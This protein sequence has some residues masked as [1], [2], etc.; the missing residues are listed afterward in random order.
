MLSANDPM[1]SFLN[2]IQVVKDALSPLELGIRK[3]AEDLE[4][5]W[6]VS[7]NTRVN[8]LEF[9]STDNRNHDNKVQICAVKK[10]SYSYSNGN[11]GNS[12]AGEERKEGF[13][14]KVP[15]RA[16]LGMFSLNMENEHNK[17]NGGRGE[18]GKKGLKDREAGSEDGSCTNC[19]QFAVTWSLL[20]SGLVQAFPSPFKT[21][22][23]GFQKVGDDDR[24]NLHLCKNELKSKVSRE[25]KQRELQ[26]QYVKAVQNDRENHKEGKHVSLEC[27]IGFIFDQLA[28]NLQKFNQSLQQADVKG[29]DYDHSTPPSE[30]SQFDH[31]R[32]VMS[33][34]EGQKVD[35]NGFLG[36]LKFARV[37]GVPSGIVGVSSSVNEEGDD[38]IS[39][40]NGEE[41]GGSSPQKL[42][43][44]LLSI[45]L[46][47]VER[48]RSTLSAVSLSELI[49]LVPHL[50]RSS[51]DYPDKKKLF[52][53]QDFFRYTESE[54][55]RFFEELDRDGDGQV[56][57]EDLEIAMKKRKL[58][59]RY[60]R[61][62]M[63]RARSHLFSKSFGWKQFLSLMEQK[64]PTI[65]R[66]YTSLCLNKS[67]TL[68]KSEILASLKNA[69]LPANEDNAV[70]MMRF[71]NADTEES[72]SYGH[73]RNFMLLLPSDR[74]QDDPRSIW[75]EAATVVAVAPP[76]EMPA[77]SVLRSALAGGL[78]CA[79]SCS[80]MHPVDTIKTRVQ[81]STLSFP[82]II[83][84]LP[85]IGVQGLYRGSIPAILGQ[86]SSH[87]LR[88]GIFEASKLVL[89]NVAP[90]LPDIQVQSISSFCSTFLG[91]AVRIPCEVLKQRLQAGLFDNVGQA[92]IG[93]WQQD[94]LKG[95]FRGTG[96][97][98]CREVPFYV[99]GMGLYAESKK[100]A[101]QLLRRE[102]EPWETIVVG[103]LSGGLAAVVTTP[104]DVMKTRMMTAQGRSLPMTMVACSILRHEGPLG[105]FKGAVPRFFWIAPLGAMN[106]AGYELARKAMDKNEE[107]SSDQPSQKKLT[108]SG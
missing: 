62:F 34:W 46:S 74:L 83:S 39:A 5:C 106:F 64:E 102:L 49:E 20:V 17:N 3:A 60:A 80:L 72:I 96:A 31:L 30:S 73:F 69:G 16:L 77:G 28:Y 95:F 94:G 42:A 70:A 53:V 57:L 2:S 100:F 103:A 85:E 23:K 97:T 93:T 61:E 50:G 25:L 36:N 63:Q 10:R 71:L 51:K 14:I 18:S 6:G 21:S 82:E 84:K 1:E 44:G 37:G 38:G 99:A 78:S 45:P 7:K 8:H 47:N 91:T 22:K 24:G 15:I 65:L 41:T 86:F 76:V 68:K 75:F 48:L 12:V 92:I 27:I 52:S 66:A 4:S 88:T 105:L 108:S 59:P 29:C 33:I 58:P 13:S 90:T 87:G 55:R 107:T 89:I 67:G 98:L 81:A 54:G 19:L 32:A 40:G 104:F 26:G 11:N 101:Q 43:S 79:F 35:V 9:S 56:T